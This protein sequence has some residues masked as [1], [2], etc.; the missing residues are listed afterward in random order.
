MFQSAEVAFLVVPFQIVIFLV[1]ISA[2]LLYQEYSD[3][4]LNQ[5]IQRQKPGDSP[6][7]EKDPGSPRQRRR[8]L[9]SQDSYL[10]R[11]SISSA[12]SLWQDL[13]RIRD[14]ATFML[15]SRAEQKLQEVGKE[16]M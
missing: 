15:M 3:V 13:P 5:E 9:S 1:H 2:S 10:Q 11:L 16:T 12:D 6:A 14:S 7:E 8:I 4:A